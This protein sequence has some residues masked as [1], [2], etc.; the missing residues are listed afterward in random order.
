M[1]REVETQHKGS[2]GHSR[3]L[4]FLPDLEE[5]TRVPPRKAVYFN[6]SGQA[7]YLLNPEEEA[8]HVCVIQRSLGYKQLLQRSAKCRQEIYWV[9]RDRGL[10]PHLTCCGSRR[11][12]VQGSSH[13]LCA[14]GRNV[15][16]REPEACGMWVATPYNR[17][18]CA[19]H[20]P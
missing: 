1:L 17:L 3:T 12:E 13:T 6:M 19:A 8:E 9:F 20:L 18:L 16:L 4:R 11:R 7:A 5:T 2:T 14:Q 10:V 15:R